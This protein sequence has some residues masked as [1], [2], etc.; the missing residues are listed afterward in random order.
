M[1]LTA[2]DDYDSGGLH[3]NGFLT[4]QREVLFCE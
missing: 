1:V 2:P 3:N 4:Q